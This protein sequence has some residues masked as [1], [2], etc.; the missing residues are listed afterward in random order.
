MTSCTSPRPSAM[1]LPISVVTVR[2]RPSFLRRK[3]RAASRRSSP[4]RGA[5]VF[6]HLSK[7]SFAWRTASL[8]S[9]LVASG[10]VARVSPVAGLCVSKRFPSDF[11]HLPPMKR[12][13]SWTIRVPSVRQE[14]P[15]AKTLAS[16]NAELLTSPGRQAL[17]FFRQRVSTVWAFRHASM[18]G[19][20]PAAFRAHS[21]RLR[22]GPR[23]DDD[24]ECHGDARENDHPCIRKKPGWAPPPVVRAE[25]REQDN[26]CG[27]ERPRS[28]CSFSTGARVWRAWRPAAENP[29]GRN[30]QQDGEYNQDLQ[31]SSKKYQESEDGEVPD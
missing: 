26:H 1:I 20:S 2:A 29:E 24:D 3:I 19:K 27:H 15:C 11:R 22:G 31:G 23:R 21:P 4:R 14:R 5:G 8:S 12:P 10:N 7:A 13:Y 18:H 30:G 6:F 28:P 17:P 9:S 25:D 16:H